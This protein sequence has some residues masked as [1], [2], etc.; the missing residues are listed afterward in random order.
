MQSVRGRVEALAKENDERK[1]ALDALFEGVLAGYFATM[2][3]P[4]DDVARCATMAEMGVATLEA[5]GFR[6][7]RQARS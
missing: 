7:V 4:G 3:E 5:S 1:A 6:I 2:Q